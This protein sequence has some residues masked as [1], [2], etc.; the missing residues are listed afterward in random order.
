MR[1]TSQLRIDAVI[2]AGAAWFLDDGAGSERFA[3]SFVGIG[4]NDSPLHLVRVDLE[5]GEKF[6]V[7]P[8]AIAA[9]YRKSFNEFLERHRKTCASLNI[10][11]RIVRTDQPL[12]TFVRAYLEERKRMSK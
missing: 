2:D 4:A 9:D 5:S 1:S 7:D 8:K 10:D 6:G 12:D 3:G 11:Y